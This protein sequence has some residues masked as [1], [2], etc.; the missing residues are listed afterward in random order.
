LMVFTGAGQS[1][2]GGPLELAAK[3]L[4]APVPAHNAVYVFALP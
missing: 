3:A 4:T 1:V 2:T